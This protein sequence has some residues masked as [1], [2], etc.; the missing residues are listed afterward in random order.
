MKNL[1]L[2]GIKSVVINGTP[3][4]TFRVDM[5]CND[6]FSELAKKE[7]ITV[8]RKERITKKGITSNVDVYTYTSMDMD[9]FDKKT[10]VLGNILFNNAQNNLKLK[11]DWCNKMPIK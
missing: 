2:F 10:S 7:G 4:R 9:D 8:I 11:Y 6:T 3:L 5:R 1:S